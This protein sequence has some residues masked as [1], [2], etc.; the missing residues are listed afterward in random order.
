MLTSFTGTAADSLSSRH[1]GKP[2]S[3]KDRDN[4]SRGSGN[5]A[6]MR[7]GAWWFNQC[8]SSHLNGVYYQAAAK[9]PFAEGINWYHWKGDHYSLKKAQ[10][11]FRPV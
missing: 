4:D 3:T 10:M 8:Q 6:V 1:Q 2:F 11:K 5:C 7:K 9:V